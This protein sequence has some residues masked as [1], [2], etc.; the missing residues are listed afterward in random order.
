MK[1]F[2]IVSFLF[3][4]YLACKQTEKPSYGTKEWTEYLGGPGEKSLFTSSAN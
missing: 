3:L 2:L 1:K 4:G